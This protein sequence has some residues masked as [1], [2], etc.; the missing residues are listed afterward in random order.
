MTSHKRRSFLRKS[1][2]GGLGLGALASLGTSTTFARP[3]LPLGSPPDWKRVRE[4]FPLNTN[5]TFFNTGSVGPSPQVVIDTVC[6]TMQDLETRASTGRARSYSTHQSLGTILNTTAEHIAVTR[7]ATEGANIAAQSLPLQAG[8]EVIITDQEHIGGAA[9]WIALQKRRGIKL[10]LL[11]LDLSGTTNLQR[12]KDAIT[13]R[14]K[15][16]AFSHVT[17]TTGMALPAK[18][19]SK[20]CRD[21]GIFCCLDGAQALGMYP[22]DLQD[23]QPDIY[24]GSGHKWLFGPKGTGVLYINPNSIERMQ[25]SYVGAYSDSV[26]DLQNLHQEYRQVAQREEYGTR[27][28]GITLG[29]GAAVDFLAGIGMDTVVKYQKELTDQLREAVSALP[30]AE[31]LSPTHPDFTSALFTFRFANHDYQEVQQALR[32][33]HGIIVRGIYEANL[34]ALRVSC[35]L[36]NSPS[37]V[38]Q[39]SEALQQLVEG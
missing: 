33:K 19:L 1:V 26:F 22:V 24:Y 35:A 31:I 17:C 36:F 11:P 8:D 9:P 32:E 27:N 23:I 39:L 6:E 25:P 10:V 37:E 21:R 34:N 3:T 5:K 28:T 16:I 2:W 14:T 15:A 20:L 38:N 30:G 18:E 4:Q 29:L 7:N 12:F 13:S